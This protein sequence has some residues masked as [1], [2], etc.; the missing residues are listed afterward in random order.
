MAPTAGEPGGCYVDFAF[1]ATLPGET[2][3]RAGMP[4]R[5]I[6]PRETEGR[7]VPSVAADSPGPFSEHS[8]SALR[9][10]YIEQNKLLKLIGE[11]QRGRSAPHA[12]ALRIREMSTAERAELRRQTLHALN[13]MRAE[14]RSRASAEA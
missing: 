8:D 6:T 5:W 11:V 9:A 2:C 4:S 13:Q 1:S 3:H 14:L 7:D 10:A 12:E